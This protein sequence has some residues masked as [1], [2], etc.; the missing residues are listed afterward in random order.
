V[1]ARDPGG[2]A[3]DDRGTHGSERF[4][5]LKRLVE[6]LRKSSQMAPGDDLSESDA[7]YLNSDDLDRLDVDQDHEV[8]PWEVNKDK[9]RIKRAGN[10]PLMND[11]GDGA[12]PVDRGEYRRPDEEFDSIDT[13]GDDELDVDEYYAFL[14]DVDRI[15]FDLDVNGDR[16]ISRDE[17]G[18]SEGDFA[19]LDRDDSGELQ[20]WEIRRA[21]ALKALR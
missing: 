15:T 13:D 21:I 9:Q 16:S 2:G 14:V 5:Q 3:P 20:P 10:H 4:E 17:S 11:L 18:L 7:P 6:T 1:Y 19:P 8:S 12:Y